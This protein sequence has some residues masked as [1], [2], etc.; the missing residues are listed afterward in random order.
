MGI[1]YR[2]YVIIK[3]DELVN[4]YDIFI[5]GECFKSIWFMHVVDNYFSIPT[6]DALWYAINVDAGAC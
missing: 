2:Y 5:F 3:L 1:T 4:Y 6:I